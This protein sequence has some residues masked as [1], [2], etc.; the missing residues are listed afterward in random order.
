MQSMQKD[1]V[2]YFIEITHRTT[3]LSLSLSQVRAKTHTHTEA[4]THTAIYTRT[5]NEYLMEQV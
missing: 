4:H 5:V 2:L 3:P 1:K